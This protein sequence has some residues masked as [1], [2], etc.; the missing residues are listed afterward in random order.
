MLPQP[1]GLMKL[2]LGS[3]CIAILWVKTVT[4]Y[5]K[6]NYSVL[7]QF[8]TEVGKEHRGLVVVDS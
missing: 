6:L 8:F 2:I 4:C 5:I 1:F 7:L 3:L